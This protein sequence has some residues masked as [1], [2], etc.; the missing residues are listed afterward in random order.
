MYIEQQQQLLPDKD[1]LQDEAR[2]TSEIVQLPFVLI[3]L[4]RYFMVPN[5]NRKFYSLDSSAL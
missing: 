3:G 2:D 5:W 4:W 1:E